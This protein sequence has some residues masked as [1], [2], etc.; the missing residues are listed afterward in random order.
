MTT[1]TY[2]HLRHVYKERLLA[3]FPQNKLNSLVEAPDKNDHGDIDFVIASNDQ[4]DFFA[5]AKH[6]GAQGT[7]ERGVRC[8]ANMAFALN[9]DLYCH[10]V[11]DRT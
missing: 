4:I 10:A 8:I 1:D 7:W 9:C 11:E 2:L 6:L 5:L 3:Y